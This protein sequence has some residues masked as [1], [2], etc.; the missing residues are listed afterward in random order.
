MSLNKI[1]WKFLQF[2]KKIISEIPNIKIQENIKFTELLHHI[3]INISGLLRL[4]SLWINGIECLNI[5]DDG[6][7]EVETFECFIILCKEFL[8]ILYKL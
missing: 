7:N 4:F 3:Y 1:T 5:A 2:R 8:N 6:L